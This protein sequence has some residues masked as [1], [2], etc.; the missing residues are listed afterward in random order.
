MKTLT[1]R[2]M[3]M[4]KYIVILLIGIGG[5]VAN[6][7]TTSAT[8]AEIKSQSTENTVAKTINAP[9]FAKNIENNKEAIILDVRTPQELAE[10]YISGAVNIDYSSSNFK[11]DLNKLDKSKPVYVYCRSGRR[12]ANAMSLLNNL[13]FTEV[14]NLNG[15]I[16]SWAQAGLPIKK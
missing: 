16:I 12:S 3:I 5:F 13:G 7:C 8:S 14:Y 9:E 1:T 6:S 10:G 15:G 2:T 4:K 11:E